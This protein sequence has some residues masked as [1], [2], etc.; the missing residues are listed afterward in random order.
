M[1]NLIY[2]MKVISF[3]QLEYQQPTDTIKNPSHR[4]IPAIDMNGINGGIESCYAP[5]D[6]RVFKIDTYANTVYYST[7]EKVMCADGIA[8]WLTIAL[9]HDND[10]TDTKVGQ[11]FLT[12][13][14]CYDEG[15]KNATGNH[16]HIEVANG[17][18]QQKAYHNINGNRVWRFHPDAELKPTEVFFA[19]SGWNVLRT[20]YTR[21][22]TFKW[23]DGRYLEEE[24]EDMKL[25]INCVKGAQYVRQ[26]IEFKNKKPNGKILACIPKGNKDAVVLNFEDGLRADGYQWIKAYYKGYDTIS[27]KNVEVEGYCQWDS[28]YFTIYKAEE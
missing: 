10:I 21:G 11:I 6:L 3:T 12:G 23:V 7:L 8:R 4:Y 14:K 2:P 25:K 26:T 20:G 5:C 15:I 17:I 24:E 16:V 27:K 1:Q 18:N 28:M 13:Q 19:L 9:T 22:V